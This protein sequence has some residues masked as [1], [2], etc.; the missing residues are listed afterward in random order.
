MTEY[1][2]PDVAKFLAFLNALPGPRTHEMSAPQARQAM[3]AMRDLADAPVGEL[4]VI[5]DVEMPGPAGPIRLRVYDAQA[6]RVPGP[7]IVFF[8]GGGFVIGDL[9]SH[10]P[11]CAEIARGLGLPVVSV[12]YRLAPEAPF[13]AAPEDCEAAARWIAGSPE[14]LGLKVTGIVTAG[15]SAGGALT[16][17]TTLALRN[18]PAAVPVIAQWPLYPVVDRA[19]DYPS[20]A[21][22]ADGYLLSSDTMRWFDEAYRPDPSDW[23]GAPLGADHAGIPPTLVVTASLDPLR[24]QGRAYAGALIA[25]GVPT[26][27]RECAGNIHGWANLRRAIPSSEGDLQGCLMA[28]RA[29]IAEAEANRVMTQ[30]AQA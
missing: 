20:Y 13:P 1:V 7:V 26:V 21:A 14:A 16:I 27:Y 8:H 6:T 22:F 9:D 25:A 5:R 30:A 29:I 10:E 17:T 3:V 23:R 24:D 15:D 4:A 28:L 18:A 2:R 11:V 19:G 12:D